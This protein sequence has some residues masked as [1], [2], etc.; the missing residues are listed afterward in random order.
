MKEY[1][2]K[3]QEL[4]PRTKTQPTSNQQLKI[5]GKVTCR[6]MAQMQ[7][8]DAHLWGVKLSKD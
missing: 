6:K 5:L 1:K 8:K 4:H 3:R 2:R 7:K